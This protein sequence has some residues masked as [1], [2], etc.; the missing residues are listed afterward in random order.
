MSTKPEG[1]WYVVNGNGVATPVPCEATAHMT[2][3]AISDGKHTAI[4]LFTRADLDAAVAEERE[5]CATVAEITSVGIAYAIRA[6]S[7]VKS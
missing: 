6:R 3:A 4:Q 7:E 1:W 2:V 5:A